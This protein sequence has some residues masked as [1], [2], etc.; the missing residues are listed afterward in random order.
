MQAFASSAMF[1]LVVDAIV[2]GAL[3]GLSAN[4]AGAL[5]V[6][7]VAAS[8]AVVVCYVAACSWLFIRRYTAT[9]RDYE[10]L[11]PHPAAHDVERPSATPD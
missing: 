3:A 10:A 1:I 8:A 9:E 5:G 2:A 6:V 11:F 4:A 7:I